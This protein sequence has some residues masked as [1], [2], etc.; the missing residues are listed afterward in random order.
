MTAL[1]LIADGAPDAVIAW[2]D[3]RPVTRAL[4]L[5]HAANL[6]ARLPDR[7]WVVDYCAE[8]YRFMVALL[9]AMLRGQQV[10]LPND[11]TARALAALAQDHPGLYCL[12]DGPV[13]DAALPACPVELI[14]GP[15]LAGP[16]PTLP[17]ARTVAKAFT[18]GST[19]KPT[20][21]D[22]SWA[23]LVT[24]T[25]A[26]ARHFGLGS[27]TA[28]VATVPPQHMFGL[29]FSVLLPLACGLSVHADRP[30]YPADI[31]A[32]LDSVPAP[33]LLVTTPVHLRALVAART[34]LPPL[35]MILSATA[36]LSAALAVQAESLWGAPVHEIYGCTEA[37]SVASRRTVAGEVWHCLGDVAISTAGDGQAILAAPRLP[38]PVTLGDI[39]ECLSPR[40]FV[41]KGRNADLVNIGGKRA[42]LAGLDAILTE[43]DG[44]ADGAFFLPDEGGGEAVTRLV[45]FAVAPGMS[46]EQ[47]RAAL[48]PHIDPLF[49]PRHLFL[50]PALPRGEAG[51][52]RREDLAALAAS[53]TK[54]GTA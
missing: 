52:L 37:G 40:Q 14:D 36:P 19:G 48:R 23:D 54:G 34:P 39:V 26:A 5:N 22:K 27:D 44:I 53:L 7:P 21:H 16:A 12:A 18:S 15:A 17:A 38:G 32:A 8:R 3:G 10:L 30:F 43:I 4:L 6:A 1:P 41:L 50:V 11:R 25:R 2:R 46:A 9:A 45:C 47:V 31:A 33:R 51:K 13:P 20:A 29:E 24:A 42:S 35:A 49:M 28:I